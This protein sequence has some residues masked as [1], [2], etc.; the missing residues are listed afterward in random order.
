MSS[1]D[2]LLDAGWEGPI[3]EEQLRSLNQAPSQKVQQILDALPDKQR[4]VLIYRFLL[5]LP[6]K[7]TADAMHLTET[8][9]KVI[10]FRALKHAAMLEQQL[11]NPAHKATNQ[12]VGD[13]R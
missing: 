2:A 5:N 9:V 8:N 1:L 6:I 3:E 10:Q 4:E 12:E 13:Q 11:F 7:E